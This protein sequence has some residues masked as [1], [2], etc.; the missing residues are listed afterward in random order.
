M[1]QSNESTSP[2]D[3]PQVILNGE[4]E[5]PKKT[6]GGRPRWVPTQAELQKVTNLAGSGVPIDTIATCMG[7]SFKTLKRA[8]AKEI[9]LAKAEGIAIC[10]GMF[11]KAVKAGEPWAIS[12]KLAIDANYREIPIVQSQQLG[13]DGKPVNPTGTVYVIKPEE[14][15]QISQDLDE[16][17]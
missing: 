11:F 8:C 6:K 17:V 12:K 9:T 10:F 13:S 5:P 7:V 16:K 14:L 3:E 4:K 1:E 2:G 15:K